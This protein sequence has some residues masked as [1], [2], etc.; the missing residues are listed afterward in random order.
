MPRLSDDFL[1]EVK[2][3]N[4][5]ESVV[6]G[7][8]NLKRRGSTLVGLCPFHNEKTPSFTVY[9]DNGS[10]YCFGCGVG[11]DVIRFIQQIE[12]LDY[13]E[14]VKKLAQRAGISMPEDGSYDDSMQRLKLRIYEMNREAARFFHS[15]LKAPEGAAALQ[16][17]TDRQLTPGTITRFGLG[18]APDSWN[19]LLQHLKSKG[20]SEPDIFTAG[21]CGRSQK[22]A[23]HYYD[24]FRN[25]VMFPIIDLRGNVVAFSGRVMPGVESD[26]QKYVNTP[27]TP[28]FKKGQIIFGMNRAKTVCAK[29]LIIV[30]G[31]MDCITLHQAGIENAVASQGTAFTAEQARLISRYTAEAVICMDADGA[32]KK[33]T[34]KVMRLLSETGVH[35]KV[36]RVPE[37][38]DPDEF[39]KHYGGAAFRKLLEGAAGDIEYQLAAARGD[40]D[41]STGDGVRQ[42]L[43]KAAE[44]L[45]RVPDG[46]TRELYAGR[47]SKEYEISKAAIL[48]RV[49]QLR[50]KQ[51]KKQR[52][53]AVRAIVQPQI[54][55]PADRLR[56]EN[57]RAAGAE[58][59]LLSLLLYHPDFYPLVQSKLTPEDFVSP[60]LGR[61][62]QRVCQLYE[63]GRTFDIAALGQDFTPQELGKIVLL[64]NGAARH[65][66]AK[67]ELQD[68]LRVMAEEQEKRNAA[69]V[70]DL[71]QA[72]WEA[73]M[74][75]LRQAKKRGS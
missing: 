33:A 38:K 52:E 19:A 31:Q 46:M 41:L 28:V 65:T 48:T 27:D 9:P 57:L 47:L 14:A 15:K 17:L 29:Q 43:A 75:K 50:A 44:V 64:Q 21:L 40:L 3:R 10:F 62:F 13:I 70:G 30:E 25:R 5:M 56:R 22:N 7:Y 1:L 63:A 53:E 24:R 54:R 68:C 73:N 26:G 55:T 45:A 23:N 60:M 61:V 59:T 42:Y 51:Y 36:V 71:S 6:G 11:G 35:I 37:G 39:V 18:Y 58:E 2:A 74:E 16:Y 49:D 69:S 8:V 20:Y 66:N 34:D 72:E 67:T 32:G 12:S 4:D